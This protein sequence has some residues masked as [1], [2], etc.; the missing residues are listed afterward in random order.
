MLRVRDNQGNSRSAG[1]AYNEAQQ[2]KEEA[3]EQKNE[4]KGAMKDQIKSHAQ[5]LNNSRDPNA[6][7]TQQKDQLR[8]AAQ[9][10]RDQAQHE[11]D[12]NGANVDRDQA[13]GQAREKA[14]QMK[15]RIPERQRAAASDAIN[16]SRQIVDDA[17]PEE[18]R[19]QFIY[20]L[21][22]VVVECQEHKDYMEAVSC[23]L[24][25]RSTMLTS[26]DLAP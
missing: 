2:R 9:G 5:D 10:K 23:N 12:R 7:L 13:Q 21:K 18:R 6:S 3:R 16:S 25:L 15:E 22:K 24:H 8:G 11:A 26:D 1:Q 17:F 19:E 4:N 14:N 20:R